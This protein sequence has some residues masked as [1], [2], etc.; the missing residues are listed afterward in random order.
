MAEPV[1]DSMNS[2]PI[3]GAMDDRRLIAMLGEY[4]LP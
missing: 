4:M 3:D 1:G 2:R